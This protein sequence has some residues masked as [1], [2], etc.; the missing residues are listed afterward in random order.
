MNKIS[1]IKVS[2]LTSHIGYW[3]RV[4]SN[5]VSHSFA[6]KLESSNITVAEWVI[7]REM[8]RDNDTTSPSHVAELTGLSRGA[9]SKLIERLLR[10][11]LVTRTEAIGDRRFQNITL[12][13]QAISLIPE[14]VALADKN[15]EKFFSALTDTERQMLLT[16]LKKL[17]KHHQMFKHPI[18]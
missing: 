16:V 2:E 1:K 3:M 8:Y 13:A 18:E 15:D 17:A 9:I 12:T 6:R 11:G 5:N 7:L 14:L 4:V 10:K